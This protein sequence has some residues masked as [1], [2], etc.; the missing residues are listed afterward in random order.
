LLLS[1]ELS[2]IGSPGRG[3]WQNTHDLPITAVESKDNP[4]LLR[5]VTADLEAPK[6]VL[7]VPLCRHCRAGTPRG[8]PPARQWNSNMNFS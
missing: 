2:L 6:A 7:K 1:S 5:V 8:R 4:D 3:R